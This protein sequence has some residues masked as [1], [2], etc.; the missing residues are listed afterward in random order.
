MNTTIVKDKLETKI[1]EQAAIF[2]ISIAEW[3][4]IKTMRDSIVVTFRT[5]EG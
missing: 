2:A 1:C 4:E 3:V 5:K